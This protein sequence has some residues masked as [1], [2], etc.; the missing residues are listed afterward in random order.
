VWSVQALRSWPD[1]PPLTTG[2]RSDSK[3][4]ARPAAGAPSFRIPP[5]AAGRCIVN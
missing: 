3:P 2:R 1:G 4:P 5:V